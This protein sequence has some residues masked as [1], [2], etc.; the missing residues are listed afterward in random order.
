MG[1]GC[2]LAGANARQDREETSKT[3]LVVE[4]SNYNRYIINLHAHH[5]AWRLRKVLPRNLTAP[6]PNS[7]DRHKLHTEA[8]QELRKKN[9]AKRAEAAVKT[10]ATKE[11]N[12]K[13][14]QVGE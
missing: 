4:H 1:G 7:S 11:R 14:L 2:R 3:E 9:P 13:E 10:K 5:N 12:K 8:A 6:E